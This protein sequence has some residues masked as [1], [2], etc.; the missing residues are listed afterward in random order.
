M[1]RHDLRKAR[2]HTLLVQHASCVC[3]T[4]EG[5]AVIILIYLIPVIIALST[6]FILFREE[7]DEGWRYP[8]EAKD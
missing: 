5:N 2:D 4:K 1:L 8:W 6:Y 7:E 3:E